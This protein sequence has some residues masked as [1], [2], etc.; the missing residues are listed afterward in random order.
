MEEPQDVKKERS[1]GEGEGRVGAA[2]DEGGC[3]ATGG[4]E[5]LPL[6]RAKSCLAESF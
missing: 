5:C 1:G 3:C 6:E 4:A 2:K